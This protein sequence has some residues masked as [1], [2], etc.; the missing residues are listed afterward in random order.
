MITCCDHSFL[1]HHSF[2]NFPG[3]TDTVES[4]QARL[5]WNKILCDFN[6]DYTRKTLCE[7]KFENHEI[8]PGSLSTVEIPQG[9]NFSSKTI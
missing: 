2:E 5:H 3:Y 1:D 4:Y 9:N 6:P 8:S 7:L